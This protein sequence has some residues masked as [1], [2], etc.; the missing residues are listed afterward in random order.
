MKIYPKGKFN[1][2]CLVFSSKI[3]YISVKKG[4]ENLG[5]VGV[6]ANHYV[7]ALPR[8]FSKVLFESTRNGIIY[9]KYICFV[10][11][12]FTIT[13]YTFVLVGMIIDNCL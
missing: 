11:S 13:I 6:F 4:D 12:Q 5:C 8:P 3:A 7:T 2:L 10:F 1:N 9:Y